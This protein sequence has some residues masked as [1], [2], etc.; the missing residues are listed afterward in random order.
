MNNKIFLSQM[1]N[2]YE[3]L[4][5]FRIEE[6]KLVLELD[7]TYKIPFSN[8]L[9]ANLNPNLFLLE[10]KE[11]L[12]VLY[13]LELLPKVQINENETKFIEQYVTRY[14]KINDLSLAN[15]D[16]DSNQTWCLS[17]PI[18]S[19]YDPIYINNPTSILIQNIINNHTSEIENSI[20]KHPKLV[21]TN[22][23]YT[24]NLEEDDDYINNFEKAGFA[25]IILIAFAVTI[26]CLYIACFI[27][28]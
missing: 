7:G 16:V 23:N 5:Y 22:P 25:T 10:P 4:R 27:I 2:I 9:L 8:V 19:S 3:S 14:L 13:M 18:Y 15:A 24:S 28:K 21:L 20:G 12:H 6:D 17:I 1:Q 26:T 11:L